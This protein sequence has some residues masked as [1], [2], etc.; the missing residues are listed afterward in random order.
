MKIVSYDKAKW[1]Y[2]AENAP[3]DIPLENGATHIAFFLRWCIEKDF[4][5]NWLQENYQAAVAYIKDK[6]L[7]Y[8]QFF[9]DDMDGCLTSEE[10]NDDGAAFANVYYDNKG[11]DSYLADYNQIIAD[12]FGEKNHDNAYFYFENTEENYAIVKKVIDK[13]Y[14]EFVQSRCKSS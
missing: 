12:A 10:L 13:R 3:T 9:M 1:H 11:D 7:D 6:Q 5:S 14:E 2:G 8:R 4:L